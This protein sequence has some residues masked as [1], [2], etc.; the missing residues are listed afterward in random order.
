MATIVLEHVSKSFLREGSLFEKVPVLKDINLRLPNGRVSVILGPSGCGKTTLLKIVAGLVKADEGKLYFSGQ[1]MSSVSPRERKLGMVFQ[2]FALYPNW[3]VKDNILSYFKFRPKTE[4]LSEEAKARFE[5]T[6]ELMGVDISY[7][8]DRKP[9][10]LSPGEKQRVA[11]AR[12]ITRDPV[13]FLLDEPFTHLDQHLREKYRT[14]LKR[15]LKEFQITT[16]YVTHDQNE[17]LLLADEIIMMRGG[18]IE[19][20]GSYNDLHRVPKNLFV[21]SFLNPNALVPALNVLKGEW[22]SPEFAGKLVGFRP[23]NLSLDTSSTPYSLE[24]NL[25]ERYD[26]P[27]LPMTLLTTELN[28]ETV[29]A[30]IPHP[31][32]QLAERLKLGIEKLM[33]FNAETELTEGYY[34]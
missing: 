14:N 29:Y 5:R 20:V 10:H 24:L 22:I 34:P 33:I 25:L 2:D 16:L 15:L 17:A 11:L 32:R 21:A 30:Y 19:Q 12:C 3:L 4:A 28:G 13:L 26:L 8:L 1:E 6:S 27:A 9:N 31:N 23:Q 18:K 7:L